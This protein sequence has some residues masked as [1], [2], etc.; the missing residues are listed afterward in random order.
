M[1]MFPVKI[2]QIG[3]EGTIGGGCSCSISLPVRGSGDW[4]MLVS[5]CALPVEGDCYSW[6]AGISP[7]K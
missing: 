6:S 5:T 1:S 3:N 4:E 2:W 7:C